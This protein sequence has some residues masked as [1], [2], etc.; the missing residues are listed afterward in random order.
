[1][2]IM[3]RGQV[4]RGILVFF[5]KIDGRVPTV[6]RNNNA[7]Q[8]EHQ[9]EKD[10]VR[11][12][13]QVTGKARSS[14]G[15]D[16]NCECGDDECDETQSFSETGDFLGATAS[17]ANPIKNGE[18]CQC[19]GPQEPYMSREHGQKFPEGST[20]VNVPPARLRKH[21]TKLGHGTAAQERVDSSEEPNHKDQPA[22]AQVARNLTRCAE[23]S[24]A[25]RI[26][27]TNS[28]AKA[29]AEYAKQWPLRLLGSNL[30]KRRKECRVSWGADCGTISSTSGTG[31]EA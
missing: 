3:E 22:I 29:Y 1:V 18:R 9:S 31:F 8:R 13:E 4:L 23:E 2:P 26:S 27:D 12:D 7:L 14:S 30:R 21:A 5:N 25:D 19:N 28:K 17:L 6:V 24:T 10:A 16:G 11:M 15:L 20:R